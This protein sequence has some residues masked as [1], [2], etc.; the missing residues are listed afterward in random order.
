MLDDVISKHILIPPKFAEYPDVEAVLW[1][2]VQSAIVGKIQVN[3]ALR[4]VREQIQRIVSKR[5]GDFAKMN[6]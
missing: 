3:E 1:R 6:G 5:D 4:N 2:T